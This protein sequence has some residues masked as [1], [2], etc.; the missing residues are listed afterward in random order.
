MIKMNTP[1]FAESVDLP[2]G[3][4]NVL[5]LKDKTLFSKTLFEVFRDDPDG[6]LKFFDTESYENVIDALKISDVLDFNANSVKILKLLYEKLE[7]DIVVGEFRDDLARKYY[8]LQ[9]SL[10][11]ILFG[12]SDLELTNEAEFS[13]RNLLKFYEV[14][15]NFVNQESFFDNLVQILNIVFELQNDKLIIFQ[16]L[17]AY[18]TVEDLNK[19]AET[20]SQKNL[21]VLLIENDFAKISSGNISVTE[22]DE[23]MF[24]SHS[25]IAQ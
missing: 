9:K 3:K 20:I 21:R 6:S 14:K 16:S 24:F 19:L 17:S 10:G 23:D 5:V 15:I 4:L 11:A 18:F 22:L 2:R 1:L 7:R 8:D 12:E 13:V 25:D